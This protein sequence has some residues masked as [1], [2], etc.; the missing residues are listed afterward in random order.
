M[1]EVPGL[2]IELPIMRKFVSN[3]IKL[4][5]DPHI[6]LR[7]APEYKTE[8]IGLPAHAAMN[9]PR[10][11]D[12]LDTFNR[13]APLAFPLIGY[14]FDRSQAVHGSSD[15]EIVYRH[16]FPEDLTYCL[17][18]TS[19]IAALNVLDDMLGIS[20]VAT[21]VEFSVAKPDGWESL[22]PEI[23]ATPFHFNAAVTKIVFPSELLQTPLPGA[24]PLN[25][26]RYVAMCETL[27]SEPAP[28][29]SPVNQVIGYLETMTDC[30]VQLS[31]AAS[32]LGYSERTLRRHLEKANSSFRTLKEHVRQSR[33][34]KLLLNTSLSMQSIADELGFDTP[35]NFARSFKRWTGLSPR[36]YRERQF[37]PQDTGQN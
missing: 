15:C 25:H 9:A 27:A 13:F 17:L 33:A 32:A 37:P 22:E 4:T 30:T 11:I 3:V 23:S 35:S 7:L 21:R 36:L 19:L 18:G 28:S 8:Y 6:W 16:K 1:F 26:Q 31:D 29:D 2:R 12:G 34:E 10:L 20:G 24:D 14:S 5:K